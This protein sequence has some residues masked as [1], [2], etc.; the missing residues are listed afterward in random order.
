MKET[1]DATPPKLAN[2]G[3]PSVPIVFQEVTQT[4]S[5]PLLRSLDAI[6]SETVLREYV[7]EFCKS[8]RTKEKKAH[9]FKSFLLT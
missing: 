2:S 5:T 8:R 6:L 1:Y 9:H 3:V 4:E 7:P